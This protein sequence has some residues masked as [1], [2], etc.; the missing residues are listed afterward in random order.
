MTVSQ[1]SELLFF[2]LSFLFGVGL[3]VLY[4]GFRLL[5][6]LLGVREGA[7]VPPKTKKEK[8][9]KCS[10]SGTVTFLLDFL[11]VLTG[12]IV[13]TLFLYEAH[14][15]I[16]RFYSLLALGIGALLY[17]KT[18][19]RATLFL[20]APIVLIVKRVAKSVL[21]PS[22]KLLKGFIR[23]FLKALRKMRCFSHEIVLN[24]SK[25]KEKKQ[26]KRK[27]QSKGKEKSLVTG[28]TY[29]FGKR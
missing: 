9:K 17:M 2:L 4:D 10:L 6:I 25:K 12:G 20:L 23:I 8:A 5:R 19:S 3:G 18:L 11:Y 15:G 28:V 1:K 22:K 24:Y 26:N 29:T 14:S 7:K 27:P 16:F 13:Y 21:Y